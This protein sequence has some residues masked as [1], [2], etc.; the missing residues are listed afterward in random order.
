MSNQPQTA[1][2]TQTR[3]LLLLG[4]IGCVLALG[5]CGGDR[6]NR[7]LAA[8]LD[9]L[10]QRGTKS[11]NSGNYRNA[12]Q[13]FETLTA[14]FP[15][16]NQAKQAQLDLIYCYY[17]NGDKD[18]AID[19]ALQFER[20]N[21]THPR[22][23][24]ALY[25]RGLAQFSG[26]HNRFHRLF[27][28][29]LAKRPPVDARESFSAFSQLVKRFPDSAYAADARQRMIFLR[30]R[31]ADHEIHV[32]RYYMRRGAYVAALNRAKYVMVNYDG[33]PAV[34]DAL[35]VIVYAYDKLGMRDL[36][37]QT[38]SVLQENYP[39]RP[40]AQPPKKEKAFI[41]F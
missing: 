2:L 31:L 12:I 36:A 19:A 16:A 30:N 33:A 27:R 21:P 1:P 17:R 38:R 24:Y 39:D 37:A 25:M 18:L 26:E 14:R 7:D 8:T 22:V 11:M 29:D 28:L 40:S 10:Y 4:L 13:Y 41:F 5:A 32:A 15:F 9:E 3:R 6:K 20:E 34:A 23:D 35:D